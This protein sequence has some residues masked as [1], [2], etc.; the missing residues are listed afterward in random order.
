MLYAF[1]KRANGGVTGLPGIHGLM[2]GCEWEWKRPIHEGDRISADAWIADVEE[3]EGRFAGRELKITSEVT[4]TDADGE[5]VGITRPYGFKMERDAGSKKE[6]Y[7][8]HQ[9]PYYSQD[10]LDKIW[11]ETVNETFRGSDKRPYE[12]TNIGDEL[13]VV[14]RGPITKSDFSVFIQGWGSQYAKAHGDWI[15][16]VRRHPDGGIR[17][18][19]GVPEAAEA[20]HWDDDLARRIGVPR[21][22]DYGPQRISWA[23]TLVTNWM[24]DHGYLRYL[25]LELR[26]PVMVGD[27]VWT[28]GT[29]VDKPEDLEGDGM[30][31]I[32]LITTNQKDEV[33]ARGSARVQLPRTTPTL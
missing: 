31:E 15:R 27:A 24:G 33:V 28:R 10:E 16:W 22:Y 14:V 7:S 23:V 12:E 6:K 9:L 26:R 25:R 20:V 2:G 29:V 13:G 8:D 17:N 3:R 1:D 21:A 11:D 4:F 19:N 5:I 18:S 32:D 30:I